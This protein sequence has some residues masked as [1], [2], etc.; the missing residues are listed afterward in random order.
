MKALRAVK[1]GVGWLDRHLPGPRL[2][3]GQRLYLDTSSQRSFSRLRGNSYEKYEW[4]AFKRWCPP[5]ARLVIDVGANIGLISIGMA[6]HLG[7]QCRILALEPN[8]ATFSSLLAN[9]KRNGASGIEPLMLAADATSGEKVFFIET[10]RSHMPGSGFSREVLH[11]KVDQSIVKTERID[12]L[13]QS[14]GLDYIKIDAEGAEFEIVRGA[15]RAI[16]AW[17]P[18]VQIE[19]HGSQMQALGTSI[20]Q[21]FDWFKTRDY[22][23]VNLVTNEPTTGDLFVRDTA[24]PESTVLRHTGY[25]Q[26]IFIPRGRA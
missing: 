25:G 18:P 1:R 15:Q 22:S 20:P 8:P 21:L 5:Q 26:V 19:V 3:N 11:G 2:I 12:N 14:N 13:V 6:N 9:V 10:A 23:A 7:S 16:E 17:R 24:W 4:D